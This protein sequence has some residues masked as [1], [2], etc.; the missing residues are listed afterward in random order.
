MASGPAESTCGE[1][2]VEEHVS[3]SCGCD[4]SELHCTQRQRFLA[5]ECR[6]VCED[7]RERE[8]CIQKGWY[9]NSDLCHCMCPNRPYP[10]C[11]SG[12]I[13]DHEETCTC[14][15]FSYRAF[16]VL[17]LV[18]VVLSLGSICAILSLV[19]C[20]RKGLGLFKHRRETRIR[21]ES[22]RVKVRSLN[23]LLGKSVPGR[24]RESSPP[25]EEMTRLKVET[26][27]P[28]IS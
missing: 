7:T 24:R 8:D 10:T 15:V 4:I 26:S 1:V 20:Y 12:Y 17:E 18:I 6:C 25:G 21:T 28:E 5:S 9:W 11:P 19:Q 16:P 22:F 13:F 3:C 14:R 23:E 27:G 2:E